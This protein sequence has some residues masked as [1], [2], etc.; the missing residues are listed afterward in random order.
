MARPR[1]HQVLPRPGNR[2]GRNWDR[3]VAIWATLNLVWVGFDLTYVPLRTFWL[4]RNLYPIPSVPLVLPLHA[5]PDITP[6]V[7]PIKGIEPHRETEA[8]RRAFD[9]LDVALQ[10]QPAPV[11]AD[12]GGPSFDTLNGKVYLVSC[13]VVQSSSFCSLC[14]SLNLV[15]ILTLE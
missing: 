9:Q 11:Q 1:W 15:V 2:V 3:F 8:Y 5:I 6:W 14:Q 12:T 13:P 4:Q 7:D 10:Q